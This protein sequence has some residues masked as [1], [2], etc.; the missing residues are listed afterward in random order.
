MS[1]ND[2]VDELAVDPLSGT[3]VLNGTP[4]KVTAARA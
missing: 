4:V 2:V 1:I 3:A